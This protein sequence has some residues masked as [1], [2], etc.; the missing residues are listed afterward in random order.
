MKDK[1]ERERE[2]EQVAEAASY[3]PHAGRVPVCVACVLPTCENV[4]EDFCFL[5]CP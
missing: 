5:F 1:E 2:K 4:E 3:P